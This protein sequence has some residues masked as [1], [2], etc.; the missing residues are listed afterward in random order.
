MVSWYQCTLHSPLV[1]PGSPQ[2]HMQPVET[3]QYTLLYGIVL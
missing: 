3:I 1:V 2:G